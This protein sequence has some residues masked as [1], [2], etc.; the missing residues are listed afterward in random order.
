MSAP[1]VV[2]VGGANVDVVARPLA[3]A[4]PASSNP[5]TVTV[6]A[7]GVARNIAEVL[8]RLGTP[9]SL[10][11]AVGG[12]QHGDLVVEVSSEAGID[13]THVRQVDG[14]T[15]AYVALLDV[16]GELVGGVS[17]MTDCDLRPDDLDA[18]LLAGAD[19]VVLDGNLSP[20]TLGAAL[21]LAGTVPVALDPVSVPKAARIREV[22]GGRRLFLVSAGAA[23]L[24]AL[25]DV[26]AEMVW[27]RR[28]PEG[29][30]LTGPDEAVDHPALF[31][32]NVV[33]VTGAG[34]AM[35]GAFLHAWL[36]G[37]TGAEAAAYGHA[38]AALTVASA[39][40]VRPDLTDELVRSLL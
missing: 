26:A 3:R 8:V 19:L 1:R 22:L 33:D 34:D 24:A 15:G 38:A 32:E 13:L 29:S 30:T 18:D 14:A 37:A 12:D 25:G 40:T 5:G 17:D 16:G 28:G 11:S 23:E 39:H 9:T 7:G 35:L 21:D 20:E 27:E 4:E 36:G 2:V 31:V 6:T 10:V